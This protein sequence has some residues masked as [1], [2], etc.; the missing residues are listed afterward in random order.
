MIKIDD[1]LGIIK[2][3]KI[4]I[5]SVR[6]KLLSALGRLLISDIKSPIDSPPFAK[7]AMDGYAVN[8]SDKSESFEILG[9][10]GAGDVPSKTVTKGT[11]V[12]IMTGAMMPEGADKIIRVE[13]AD[14]ENNRAVPHREETKSNVIGKAE[15]LKTGD[16]VLSARKLM[17]KDIGII[18]SLGM[19]AVEVAEQPVIGVITT[20]SELKDPGNRLKP[21]EIYNSNGLQ[22]CAQIIASGCIPKYYG[23]VE[24]NRSKLSGTVSRSFSECDIVLLSGGVSKGDYDFVPDVLKENGLN[25]LFHRVAIKP[26]KPVLFGRKDNLFAFGLPGNPVSAF[27]IFEIFVKTLLYQLAGLEYKPVLFHGRLKRDIHRSDTERTEFHPVYTYKEDVI[28][29]KYHGSS[30]LNAMAMANGLILIPRGVSELKAGDCVD[31]RPV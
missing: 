20:G 15:N 7:A 14:E 22:L 28:P 30:H 16:M 11:C 18:A 24:D 29:V 19:E 10:I 2:N 5:K 13:Y 25:I 12:K 21:G 27:V 9:I 1:A 4:K 6:V 31:V 26:G 17:P 23:I 3:E 8:S